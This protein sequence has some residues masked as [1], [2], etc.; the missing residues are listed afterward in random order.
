MNLAR[1]ARIS[2]IGAL[3]LSGAIAQSVSDTALKNLRFRSIGPAVMGGRID[4]LAVVEAEPNVFYVGAA[5]GG[6]FKTINGGQS[7]QAIFEDQ[8]NPSIGDLALAPSNPLSSTRAPASPI[9]G[10]ALRG[11]MACINL[12]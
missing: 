8:P 10:R 5:A 7:W 6:I 9:T 3:L 2:A 4:D 11:V 12:P 1:S